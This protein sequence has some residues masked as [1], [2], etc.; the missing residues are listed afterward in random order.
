MNGNR[1]APE[2]LK[3][4]AADSIQVTQ[5]EQP[6]LYGGSLTVQP[7]AYGT[8]TLV[9][10]V[11]LETYLRGVVPHEIGQEAPK[12]AAE[13]QGDYCSNLCFTKSAPLPS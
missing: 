7:N 12:T 13:A 5:E 10:Q 4:T 1:Y 6:H 8:F 3:I 9:N 2:Q 11:P